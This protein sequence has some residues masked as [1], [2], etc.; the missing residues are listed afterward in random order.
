MKKGLLLFLVLATFALNA[1]Q[2]YVPDD[3]FEQ[4]LINLGYDSGTLDDYVPTNNIAN[5]AYLDLTSRGINDLTGIE[6]FT[7]LFYLNCTSNNLDRLEL[8]NN[9]ALQELVC[10]GNNIKVLDL[11]QNSSLNKFSAYNNQLVYLNLKNGNNSNL[12]GADF[13]A[14]SNPNLTCI[15]VDDIA[16]STAYWTNIDAQSSFSLDCEY[17]YVPD[18]NFVQAL[19]DLGYGISSLW[20]YD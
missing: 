3:N 18:D 8:R 12:A 6:D 13:Y 16:Y 11:S 7:G 14:G 15:E 9:V 2:T 5:V 10:N 4:E 1:Q 19:I 17:T 20:K